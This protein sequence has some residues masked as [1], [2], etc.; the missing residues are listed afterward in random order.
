MQPQFKP[1]IRVFPVQE[2]SIIESA[3]RFISFPSQHHAGAGHPIDFDL[4]LPVI[5][6]TQKLFSGYPI[7]GKKPG[8]R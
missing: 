6:K 4:L 8:K 2:K 3:H 7:V 5:A 1:Q